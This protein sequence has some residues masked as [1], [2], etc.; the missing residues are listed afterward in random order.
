MLNYLPNEIL[1]YLNI[2]L[3]NQFNCFYVLNDKKNLIN[4]KYIAINRIKLFYKLLKDIYQLKKK[5]YIF[6]NN[7][8]RVPY[9]QNR[10]CYFYAPFVKNGLCRFCE[11]DEKCHILKEKSS[12]LLYDLCYKRIKS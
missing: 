12:N 3:S 5:F 11:Q 10:N 8:F 7:C 6:T 4:I 1:L 9:Y 2:P